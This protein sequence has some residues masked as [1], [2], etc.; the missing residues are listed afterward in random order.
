MHSPPL[1]APRM[2]LPQS[3]SGVHKLLGGHCADKARNVRVTLCRARPRGGAC[4]PCCCGGVLTAAARPPPAFA[5]DLAAA[6]CLRV[7]RAARSSL[8]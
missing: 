7:C 5:C 4:G 3:A 8:W 6:F 1:R 2:W